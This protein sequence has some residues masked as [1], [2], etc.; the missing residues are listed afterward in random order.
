MLIILSSVDKSETIV[1][2]IVKA[3]KGKD[4]AGAFD[5]II[6]PETYVKCA[7]ITHQLGGTQILQTVLP[8]HMPY[9]EPL[10]GKVE[11]RYSKLI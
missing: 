8:A 2:D 4:F 6:G 11:I 10:P 1:E 7:E 3:L 9:D 5:A